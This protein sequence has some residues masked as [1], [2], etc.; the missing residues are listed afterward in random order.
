LQS[1]DIVALVME[2]RP[3]F[4]V[5][6]DV[7]FGLITVHQQIWLG[8]AKLGVITAFI[9]YRLTG[10]SL[11]GVLKTSGAKAMIIGT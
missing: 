5:I 2:N 7:I 3:E 4:F 6:Q 11:I 1:G 10:A 8:M 9:N